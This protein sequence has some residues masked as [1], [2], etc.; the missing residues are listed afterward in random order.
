MCGVMQ[1]L[2]MLERGWVETPPLPRER[3][4]IVAITVRKGNGVHETPQEIEIDVERGVRGDRWYGPSAKRHSQV[5]LINA[6]VASLIGSATASGDNFCVSLD[7]SEDNLPPGT[8][9]EI[10]SAV[11]AITAKPHRGCSKFCARFGEDVMSWVNLEHNLPLR[12]R[13]VH[14]EVIRSGVVKIGDPVLVRR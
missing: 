10:G 12:L 4:A 13:G 9:L 1:T 2:E 3:G 14:A 6:T 7:L 11:L 8:E 5:T